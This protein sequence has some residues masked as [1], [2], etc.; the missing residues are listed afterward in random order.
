M[1]INLSKFDF[2]LKYILETKIGKVDELSKR[3]DQKVGMK[4]NKEQI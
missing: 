2:T 3:L 4:N 1:N